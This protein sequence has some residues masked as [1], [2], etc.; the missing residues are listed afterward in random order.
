MAEEQQMVYGYSEV[1]RLL[2]HVIHEALQQGAKIDEIYA[3][4][5]AQ[6]EIVNVQL[7]QAIVFQQAR[8]ASSA[9][10]DMDP[11]AE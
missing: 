5:A 6:K 1:F 8:A 2:Q 3:A 11:K 4:L 9:Q 7:A 10:D